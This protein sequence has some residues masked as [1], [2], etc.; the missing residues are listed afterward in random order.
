MRVIEFCDYRALS[1]RAL[2][3]IQVFFVQYFIY[4]Q[5]EELKKRDTFLMEINKAI[6]HYYSIDCFLSDAK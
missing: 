4:K 3:L 5:N 2:S 6:N 1:I